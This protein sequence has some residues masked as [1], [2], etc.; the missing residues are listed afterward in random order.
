MS[1]GNIAQYEVILKNKI[2]DQ[3]E[4]W[5][6]VI[7]SKKTPIILDPIQKKF[8]HLIFRYIGSLTKFPKIIGKN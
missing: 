2:H 5:W 7:I 4:T 6:L 8:T 3:M 1:G